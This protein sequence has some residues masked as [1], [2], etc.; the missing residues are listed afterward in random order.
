MTQRLL[1]L[2]MDG[3]G[4]GPED[5]ESNPFSQAKMPFLRSILGGKGVVAGSAPY[6]GERASLLALDARLGVPGLPQSATGQS[7]LLTGAN[8][9]AELG[10]HYGPKPNPEVAAFLQ[11][12]TLFSEVKRSGKRAALL[13]AYPPRYFEA[14]ESGR[15]ILSAIPMAVTNA[16]I[17]LRTKDDLFSGGALSVDFTGEGWRGQLD[18][19]DTPVLTANEAGERMAELASELDFAFFEYWPSDYAGHRQDMDAALGLL[20]TFDAVLESLVAAWNG[21]DG[22]ILLTSDHGNMEDLS[23]RR[24]THNPVPAI[25]IGE[26]DTRG[27][28]VEGLHDLTDI[29]PAIRRSLEIL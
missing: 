5:P 11:N 23:T 1:F 28:F 9:P 4:L 27:Q 25:V 15:R 20:G 21:V 26:T 29:A 10:Y 17:P 18:I 16:G 8:I 6:H 12:G 19:P 13:N 22:L 3:I 2:F 14:V 24:H 7:V